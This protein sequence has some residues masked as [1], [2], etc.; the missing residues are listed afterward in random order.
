MMGSSSSPDQYVL[1]GKITGVHGVRGMLK[2]MPYAGDPESLLHYEQ[3]HIKRGNEITLWTF[4]KGQVYQ[5]KGLLMK[6]K[7][8]DTPEAGRLWVGAELL[9]DRTLM[10]PLEEGY[11]WADLEGLAVYT[12]EGLYLGKVSHLFETGANDVLVVKN[13][14]HELLIPYV[15]GHIVK[16]VNLEE[17][18]LIV[19]W[20]ASDEV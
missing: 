12:V 5:E 3:W 1:A 7:G 10:P 8:L 11:Y 6:F 19:D 20:E 17:G 13:E 2:V 9:L 4:E 18:K 14:E 15:S 16:D